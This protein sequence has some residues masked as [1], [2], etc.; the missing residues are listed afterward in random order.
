MALVHVH[1]PALV[2]G[3]DDRCIFLGQLLLEPAEKDALNLV[4]NVADMPTVRA[5]VGVLEKGNICCSKSPE[6]P[7][8]L[9]Q[10]K[11]AW[12]W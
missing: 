5:V 9:E 2:E 3:A 12:P 8:Q 11:G 10:R 1:Q 6:L 7:R 4:P